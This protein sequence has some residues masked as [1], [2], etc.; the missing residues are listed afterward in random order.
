MYRRE[1]VIKSFY[2]SMIISETDFFLKIREVSL[3]RVS[4]RYAEVEAVISEGY[5]SKSK[6]DI[7]M[8]RVR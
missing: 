3:W 6:L 7:K 5:C 2:S 4:C 1:K 8:T